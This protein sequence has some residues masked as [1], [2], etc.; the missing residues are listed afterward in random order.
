MSER[1]KKI[2]RFAAVPIVFAF[3]AAMMLFMLPR[4]HTQQDYAI[5]GTCA[6]LV[7]LIAVFAAIGG[8]SAVMKGPR[9]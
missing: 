6:T 9:R 5:A 1:S 2:A 3:T 8:V 7:S 4:P